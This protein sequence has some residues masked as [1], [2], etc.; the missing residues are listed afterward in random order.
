MRVEENIDGTGSNL[1]SLHVFD[2][3][4]IL[5][6]M[7]PLDQLASA[8]DMNPEGIDDLRL[9]GLASLHG[10]LLDLL[11]YGSLIDGAIKSAYD[12]ITLIISISRKVIIWV[13]FDV[14]RVSVGHGLERESFEFL[15]FDVRS[16]GLEVWAP[17][18]VL[19]DSRHVRLSIISTT[20]PG[21]D[22]GVQL[23]GIEVFLD[24]SLQNEAKDEC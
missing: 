21:R 2:N 13:F 16:W 5:Q 12:P 1:E 23:D 3:P 19:G 11:K 7:F 10:T 14:I 15:D 6:Q 20:V 18:F 4:R 9:G 24:Q 22:Y 17:R 8:L